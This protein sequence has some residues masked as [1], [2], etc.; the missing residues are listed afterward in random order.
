MLCLPKNKVYEIGSREASLGSG[1][2]LKIIGLNI[3]FLWNASNVGSRLWSVCV[4]SQNKTPKELPDVLTKSLL[5][6]LPIKRN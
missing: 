5:K 2:G 6:G 4:S 1:P 3:L